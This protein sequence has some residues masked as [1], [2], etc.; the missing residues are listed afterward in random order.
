METYLSG[1][2][3]H[4]DDIIRLFEASFSASEGAEEGAVI[5][6]LVTNLLANADGQDLR[7]FSALQ[8]DRIV[9]SIMLSPLK[10]METDRLVFL[11]SPVAVKTEVQGQGVGQ[12]LLRHGLA[13][14]AASGVDI[15][16]TYGDPKFYGRVG[17]VPVSEAIVPAPLPLS[18]P[19]GWLATSLTGQPLTPLSGPSR[20]VRALDNP[21]YW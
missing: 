12:R 18:Y 2:D 19:E 17:F 14:L 8:A 7:V 20:C 21:D 9:G 1:S 15:V 3:A 5:G 10:F 16:V 4:T 13:A 6:H 11:L